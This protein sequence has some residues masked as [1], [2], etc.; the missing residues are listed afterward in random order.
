[1][2]CQCSLFRWIECIETSRN[3]IPHWC[4]IINFDVS[5]NTDMECHVYLKEQVWMP[6]TCNNMPGDWNENENG[7]MWALI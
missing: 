3:Q 2:K 6:R 1:M 4:S 5:S 7:N